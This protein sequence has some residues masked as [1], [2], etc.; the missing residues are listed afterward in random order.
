[1]AVEAPAGP[2]QP[3]ARGE[4]VLNRRW[5][6]LRGDRSQHWTAG[7][8]FPSGGR[9]NS[10]GG[11][12][13]WGGPEQLSAAGKSYL[14][15]LI[16]FPGAQKSSSGAPKRFKA[17]GKQYSGDRK[18]FQ[19]APMSFRTAPK[20]YSTAPKL[21]WA[22]VPRDAG[23]Q[24]AAP[25]RQGVERAHLPKRDITRSP[26]LPRPLRDLCVLCVLPVRHAKHTSPPAGR[27][28][29]PETPPS[30]SG[31][32]DVGSRLVEEAAR[33]GAHAPGGRMPPPRPPAR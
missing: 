9:H 20:L 30:Q 6:A 28:G 11:K 4:N 10:G 1:M 24:D 27:A 22:A 18:W 32:V 12:W 3:P 16:P 33:A 31:L 13:F 15:P 25:P 19:A 8:W 26:P 7:G 29:P 17:A 21:L 2:I 14:G 5:K 23:R